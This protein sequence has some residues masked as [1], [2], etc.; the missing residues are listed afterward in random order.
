MFYVTLHSTYNSIHI[1]N[2][3]ENALKYNM[4][5]V[6]GNHIHKHFAII[7]IC[8]IIYVTCALLPIFMCISPQSFSDEES[9]AQS[10]YVVGTGS[11][12]TRGRSRAET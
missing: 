11:E 9:S 8:I 6:F 7:L 5:S 4:I 3:V 12:I 1:N 2:T 10:L